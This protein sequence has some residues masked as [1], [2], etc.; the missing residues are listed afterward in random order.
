MGSGNVG[1][2]VKVGGMKNVGCPAATVGDGGI[3]TVN[4]LVQIPNCV[5][6]EALTHPSKPC[7]LT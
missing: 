2:G 4:K 5:T 1:S 7:T 6:Y 3:C